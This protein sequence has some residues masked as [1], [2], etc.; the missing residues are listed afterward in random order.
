MDGGRHRRLR[1]WAGLNLLLLG[2][3][4]L[5]SLTYPVDELSRRLGDEYF[6]LRGTRATSRNVGLVLIDDNSLSQYGR[7]PWPRSLLARLI[8]AASAQRP[9]ALGVDI[10]LSEPGDEKDDRD[11]A[12]AFKEAGNVVLAAK[13]SGSPEGQMWEEPLPVFARVAAGVGH[14]QAVLGPDGICRSVPAS[15]MS[16]DGLLPA[17]AVAVASVAR[18][19]TRTEPVAE[20][21]SAAR[22]WPQGEAPIEQLSPRPLLVDFHSQVLLGQFTPPFS[23]V[24]AAD[25][26]R[27]SAGK[28]L[29]NKAVL[30][31]FGATE[32]SDGFPTPV[33]DRLPM[34]GVEIHANLVDELL[35]GRDLQPLG[36]GTQVLLLVGASLLL[37]W[38]LLRWPGLAGLLLLGVLTVAGYAAGYVLFAHAR[39]LI[40]FGPFLCLGVLAAPL[41]ELESLV[42]VDRGLT[43]NLRQLQGTLRKATPKMTVGLRAALSSEAP[44]PAGDVHWK[45]ATLNQ[46]QTEL[47]SLYAFDQTLLESM[48]EGL[49]VFAPNGRLLFQNPRWERFCETLHWQPAASLEEFLTALGQPG[50]RAKLAQPGTRLETELLVNNW[51]WQVRALTLPSSAA[52]GTGALMVVA[53]DLTA[54]L[55]RDRARAEALGFVT[56]EL[57]TPLVS[58][59]GFAE[60]LLR[61]PDTSGSTEAAETIFRESKRLV[62]M[63]NTYL[64]VLRLE[65]GAYPLRDDV[66]DIQGTLT[67]LERLMQPLAEAADMNVKV[68]ADPALPLLRGDPHL[69]AGALLNLLS[70]AVKYG[71]RGSEVRLRALAEAD[72]VVFEVWNHGPAISPEDLAHLF[73][74]FYRQ[75]EHEASAAGWGLGLAFVKRIA[76]GH[77]GKVEA[78]SDAAV[79]TCFRIALPSTPALGCEVRL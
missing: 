74:P 18:G 73:E 50:W 23:V 13:I 8:R 72:T 47:S 51:L 24:S 78:R 53:A 15:E 61:Y 21:L 62:A 4:G 22:T 49:A 20:E 28:D 30:L 63:I 41:A 35:A 67:Q 45:V 26:L 37:T 1:R 6:R 44:A 79:G 46:L 25:L 64:D 9:R 39:R 42:V 66:I 36:G 58:I 75:A 70:N 3:V 57:R 5:L 48:Q 29:R 27:G 19:S 12:E 55:E 17:L 16:P 71:S 11:L 54:R 32:I 76:E 43:R 68:E 60:F 65:S 2:L 10:L 40:A 77:G 69:I 38:V 31:G 34:P 59:Q 14:V 33:S 7:W 56:H 52:A